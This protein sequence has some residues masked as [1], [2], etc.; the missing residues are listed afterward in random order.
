M[1]DNLMVWHFEYNHVLLQLPYHREHESNQPLYK[2]HPQ[3][4]SQF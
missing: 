4:G 3:T 2:Y 1:N